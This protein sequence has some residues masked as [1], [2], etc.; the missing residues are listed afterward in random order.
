MNPLIRRSALAACALAASSLMLLPARAQTEALETGCRQHNAVV[1]AFIQFSQSSV[2]I[3]A[4]LAELQ[5][6]PMVQQLG[7]TSRAARTDFRRLRQ[8][9]QPRD[10]C[11][12]RWQQQ[13]IT[14][15]CPLRYAGQCQPFSELCRQVLQA[16]NSEVSATIQHCFLHFPREDSGSAKLSQGISLICV[17]GGDDRHQFDQRPGWQQPQ[18]FSRVVRLPEG[19]RTFAGGNT[20]CRL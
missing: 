7:L 3:A 11:T 2:N 20:K 14:P 17:A 9:V 10:C 13:R 6:G 19:Q 15:R 1:L 12:A 5:I 18:P 16:V 4:N 8:I